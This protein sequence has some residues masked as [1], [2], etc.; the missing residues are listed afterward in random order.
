MSFSLLFFLLLFV[1]LRRLSEQVHQLQLQVAEGN[2]RQDERVRRLDFVVAFW[3]RTQVVFLLSKLRS[4]EALIMRQD[5]L[6]NALWQQQA[7]FKNI[8]RLTELVRM[9]HESYT[10]VA[11]NQKELF[12]VLMGVP[13]TDVHFVLHY[14]S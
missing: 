12:S 1:Q 4:M 7:E 2:G 11:Q 3:R 9:N 5:Q 8:L 10:A 14:Y 13:P 6:L